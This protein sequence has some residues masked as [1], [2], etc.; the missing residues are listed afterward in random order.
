MG[1]VNL[2]SQVL[3]KRIANADHLLQGLPSERRL[4]DELG[5]S[6][7]TV[8]SAVQ[9]LVKQ[10]I[11]VRGE[12]GRLVV[13][14]DERKGQTRILG[15]VMPVGGGADYELWREAVVGALE[16]HSVT[17]RPLNYAHWGD[18]SISE[19]VAGFDGLFFI[20]IT[21]EKIPGWLTSKMREA[22]CRVVVLDQDETEAGLPSVVLFPPAAERP[23]FDHLLALGHRRIDC[24]NTQEENGII[25]GRIAVWGQFL[26]EKGLTG[27]LRSLPVRRPIEAGYRIVRETLAESRPLAA[28]L[29][30]TTGPAAI[31]AMRALREAKLEVGR[32]VSVCAVND[33]GLGRFLY[34][35]LTAMESPSRI[36]YLR[37]PVDWMVGDG[38]WEGPLLIQPQA[39]PIFE[40]ESTGPVPQTPVAGIYGR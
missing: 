34:I 17:L 5:M 28:A 36:L 32:D 37:Q 4:A 20:P 31:G 38:D 27:Q 6:R 29:F 12:N 24:I 23:L 3:K 16:G 11:L 9:G 39:A 21:N 7:N 30:C 18:P 19:A 40:G 33:E 8:R 10:G 14:R 35:S 15:L 13:G 25:S 2:V 1:K 26:Q 22:G